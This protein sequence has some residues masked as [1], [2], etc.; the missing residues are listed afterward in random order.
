MALDL[1]PAHLAT[2]A[3]LRQIAIDQAD[4]D[5]A[6]DSYRECER[7]LLRIGEELRLTSETET[8]GVS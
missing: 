8:I 5:R 1:D 2:L 7:V 6:A 3:A 4:W